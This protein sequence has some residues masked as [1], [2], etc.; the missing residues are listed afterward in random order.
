MDYFNSVKLL[1]SVWPSY[2]FNTSEVVYT[3]VCYTAPALVFGQFSL[4]AKIPA[5]YSIASICRSLEENIFHMLQT[6]NVTRVYQPE[7]KMCH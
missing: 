5:V 1:F 7:T 6:C 2:L 3:Y 4:C